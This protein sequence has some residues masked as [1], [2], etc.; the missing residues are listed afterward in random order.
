MLCNCC[1]LPCLYLLKRRLSY[2][3]I[4]SMVSPCSVTPTPY[5]PRT[6]PV[7]SLLY[8]SIQVLHKFG[9]PS[10]EWFKPITTRNQRPDNS[11]SVIQHG[12]NSDSRC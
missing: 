8:Y 11:I 4:W 12:R 3:N 7:A 1:V 10:Q 5:E 6:G 2:L 9:E